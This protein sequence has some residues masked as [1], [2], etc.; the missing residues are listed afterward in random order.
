[1]RLLKHILVVAWLI[2]SIGYTQTWV[3]LTKEGIQAY[4]NHEYDKA[5][6]LHE[7]ALKQAVKESGKQSQ[8][9]SASLN[10][11]GQAYKEL[12]QYPR[13]ETYFLEEMGIE[14]KLNGKTTIEYAAVL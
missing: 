2:G 5:I 9:Y 12:A 13:A 10:N 3:D 7:K 1:M 8:M 6:V 11:L 4:K 14:E